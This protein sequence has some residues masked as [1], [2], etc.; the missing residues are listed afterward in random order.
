MLGSKIKEV[1]KD[2]YLKCRINGLYTKNN[3]KKNSKI[4]ANNIYVSFPRIGISDR[5]EEL[6]TKLKTKKRIKKK[7]PILW[8]NLKI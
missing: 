4:K 3:I 8:E 5:Y 2:E 7:S 6:V 1:E